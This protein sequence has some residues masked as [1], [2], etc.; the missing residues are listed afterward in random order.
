MLPGGM[1]QFLACSGGLSQLPLGHQAPEPGW[2]RAATI[3]V[4]A[5]R[6][7][8]R[9]DRIHGVPHWRARGPAGLLQ[10]RK[11]GVRGQWVTASA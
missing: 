3:S 5:L 10:T 2:G 4:S 6:S 7:V 8:T 1:A 9:E 11:V